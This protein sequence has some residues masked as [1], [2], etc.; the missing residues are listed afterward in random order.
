ML[1]AGALQAALSDLELAARDA[2]GPRT[3]NALEHVRTVW[4]PTREQLSAL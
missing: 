4:T 1:G 2:D 3:R